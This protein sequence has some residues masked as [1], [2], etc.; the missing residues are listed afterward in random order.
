M[1]ALLLAGTGAALATLALGALVGAPN[2]F[3]VPENTS[4]AGR[5]VATRAAGGQAPRER[6][7]FELG[8]AA[9]ALRRV[10]VDAAVGG[11]WGEMGE[12]CGR[13]GRRAWGCEDRKGSAE[14]GGMGAGEG[15]G[16]NRTGDG[17][18]TWRRRW[19]ARARARASVVVGGG[20]AGG[21][22]RRWG[23][24]C[25]DTARRQRGGGMGQAQG[26]A[27]GQTVRCRCTAGEGDGGAEAGWD[28]QGGTGSETRV[29]RQTGTWRGRSGMGMAM[30]TC[31]AGAQQGGTGRGRGWR[32]QVLD[33]VGEGRGGRLRGGRG[34]SGAG[35]WRASVPLVQIHEYVWR[36]QQNS[37]WRRGRAVYRGAGGVGVGR[38]AG[39]TWKRRPALPTTQVQIDYTPTPHPAPLP[40][41][42]SPCQ[43]VCGQFARG[44]N[45]QSTSSQKGNSFAFFGHRPPSH[46]AT[47]W[48]CHLIPHCPTLPLS[49]IA[50][51]TRQKGGGKKIQ[52]RQTPDSTPQRRRTGVLHTV[53]GGAMG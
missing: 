7:R 9:G 14:G 19:E 12:R 47:L 53:S 44:V 33:S 22:G 26:R 5:R 27:H 8:V 30:Q 43:L 29:Q 48:A 21:W 18:G 16:W 6:R 46:H 49:R 42:A 45:P 20:D 4:R 34:G 40:L 28:R 15:R 41:R 52:K 39:G 11:A 17:T 35:A 24:V 25:G 10:R 38:R 3:P 37:R 1:L 32:A 2:R 13:G 36:A 31:G 50:T 51:D 23:G